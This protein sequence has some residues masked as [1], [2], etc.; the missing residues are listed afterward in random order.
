MTNR[1]FSPAGR[2]SRRSAVALLAGA[3]RRRLSSSR[4]RAGAARAPRARASSAIDIGGGSPRLAV[5]DFLAAHARRRDQGHCRHHR[6]GAV[7][8]P[9]TSSASSTWSRATPTRRSRCRRRSTRSRSIAGASSGAEGLVHRHG[10]QDRAPASPSRCGCSTSPARPRRSR[11]NTAARPPT[12]GSFAHTISD[13]IHK[14]QR[15]LTGVARTK[16]TFSSDRDGERMKGTVY[17][18]RIKEI[19][20]ADYDGANPRR[21]TVNRSLNINPVWSSDGKAIAYTSYRRSNFPDILHPAH[22]RGHAARVAGARHRP[23]PQPP[24]GVVARRHQDR[25]HDLPRR[26]RGDLRDGRQRRQRA[27]HH[28]AP[29][30]STRRR[31]GRRP[32]TRSPSPRIAPAR[33]RS[34]SSTPTASASRGAS[35]PT[36]AGPTAP[37]GRRRR[38]TRSPTRPSPGPASTSRSTTS[39]PAPRAASPTARART[40]ARRSRRPAA[41]SPSRRPAWATSRS[42]SSAATA[43]VCAR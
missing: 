21:I 36:R 27:P 17:D 38:S 3:R 31:R 7:G 10:A 13:E 43:T 28:A 16:L 24:A 39:P 15:N 41:T 30:A 18:R 29:A 2:H 9:R 12:R 5:P 20:I 25:V 4:R 22:L 35:R 32:A 19:Y 40:R 23:H 6:P 26:Q 11:R 42:S 14:Q 34:T 1:S 33:R 37:P 8:R